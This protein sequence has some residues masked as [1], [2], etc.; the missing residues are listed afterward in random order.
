[1]K[2]SEDLF[3]QRQWDG[4]VEMAVSIL[5]P[6]CVISMCEIST[7]HQPFQSDAQKLTHLALCVGVQQLETPQPHTR[8]R[9]HVD[10][11]A[12]T[13]PQ[14]QQLLHPAHPAGEAA[15]LPSLTASAH[16]QDG[17]HLPLCVTLQAH[18]PRQISPTPAASSVQGR[19]A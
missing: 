6:L 1:M 19:R 9:V 11:H 5:P 18:T 17:P 2:I 7:T 10:V 8:L 12:L 15:G 13:G 3:V 4:A 16:C 14:P